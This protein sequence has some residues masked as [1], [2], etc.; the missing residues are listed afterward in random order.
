MKITLE[1]DNHQQMLAWARDLL[2]LDCPT[3]PGPV[4]EFVEDPIEILELTV[5]SANCL[6]AVGLYRVS[7][8]VKAL[9]LGDDKF[10]RSVPNLGRKS[11]AELQQQ[12]MCYKQPKCTA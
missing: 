11:L 8:V 7:E 5:R 2:G 9:T 10:L 3:Q 6:K 1:F 4:P 12:L